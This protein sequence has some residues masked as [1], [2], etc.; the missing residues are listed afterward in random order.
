[1]RGVI[2]NRFCQARFCSNP[3]LLGIAV[4]LVELYEPLTRETLPDQWTALVAAFENSIA[5]R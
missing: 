1:M 4:A 5:K 2:W 3:M